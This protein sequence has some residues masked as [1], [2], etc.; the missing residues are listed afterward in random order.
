MFD[1]FSK[2]ST[3]INEP[4]KFFQNYRGILGGGRSFIRWKLFF[5]FLGDVIYKME[6]FFRQD[7]FW[8]VIIK[9]SKK[10]FR[11][12]HENTPKNHDLSIIATSFFFQNS[13]FFLGV[14]E[15]VVASDY[16]FFFFFET[17]YVFFHR[18]EKIVYQFYS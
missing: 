3:Y 11:A 6:T 12:S 8:E 10:N 14:I 5:R 7:F 1:K 16:D 17:I 2:K 4:P 9:M 18:I 15:K 13:N